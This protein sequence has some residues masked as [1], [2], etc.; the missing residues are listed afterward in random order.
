MYVSVLA[1]IHA[2]FR[3]WYE[4]HGKVNVKQRGFHHLALWFHCHIFVAQDRNV[5]NFLVLSAVVFLQCYACP[6]IFKLKFYP[7]NCICHHSS[8]KKEYKVFVLWFVFVLHG[9]SPILFTFDFGLLWRFVRTCVIDFLTLTNQPV[10][11]VMESTAMFKALKFSY[12][13]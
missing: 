6:I 8:F 7:S 5:F 9:F 10:L 12:G 13:R 3:K 4:M 1:T 2:P 11:F